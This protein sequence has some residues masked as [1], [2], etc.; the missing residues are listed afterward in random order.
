MEIYEQ[1]GSKVVA[2]SFCRRG[3]CDKS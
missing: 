2:K 3:V 1:L